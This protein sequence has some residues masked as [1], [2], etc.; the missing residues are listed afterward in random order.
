MYIH[1]SERI[2][3]RSVKVVPSQRDYTDRL[4]ALA[5]AYYANVPAILWGPPGQGKSS[6]V[7]AFARD[8]QQDLEVIIASIREPSDFNGL[9]VQVGDAVT[10]APPT[11]LRN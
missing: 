4:T 5:L 6:L 10:F 3:P 11:W 9:P 1:F 7:E 2:Y 8:L